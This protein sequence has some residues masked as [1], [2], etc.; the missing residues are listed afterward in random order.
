MGG[1]QAEPWERK[2]PMGPGFLGASRP[3]VSS[4]GGQIVNIRGL[5]AP[6][7]FKEQKLKPTENHQRDFT[8][9]RACYLNVCTCI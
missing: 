5:Q 3:V 8:N 6:S 4:M 1:V 7:R 2:L 9:I